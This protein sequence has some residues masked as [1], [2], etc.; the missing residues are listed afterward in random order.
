MIKKS[1]IHYH[2]FLH[3]FRTAV[4]FVSGFII[5]EMLAKLEKKWNEDNPS[6]KI[7]NFSKRKIIKFLLI[8]LIDMILLYII[9]FIFKVDI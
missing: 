9:F 5:Y 8:L 1:N 2:I 6:N 3:A 4:I 7:F